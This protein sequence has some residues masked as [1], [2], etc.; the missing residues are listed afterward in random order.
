M[1]GILEPISSVTSFLIF[2]TT[3][4]RIIPLSDKARALWAVTVTLLVSIALTIFSSSCLFCLF[5]Y[6]FEISFFSQGKKGLGKKPEGLLKRKG[7]SLRLHQQN[8]FGSFP[9]KS[10]PQLRWGSFHQKK[11]PPVLGCWDF[12][13]RLSILER[14]KRLDWNMRGQTIPEGLFEIC[15]VFVFLRDQSNFSDCGN[16]SFQFQGS[17]MLCSTCKTRAIFLLAT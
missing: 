13:F 6:L 14:K 5:I 1:I 3:W 15:W 9:Q 8:K 16:S 17:I 2:S 11:I 7:K 4:L 10:P 12:N